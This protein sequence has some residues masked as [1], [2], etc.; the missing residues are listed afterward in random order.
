MEGKLVTLFMFMFMLSKYLFFSL[1]PKGPNSALMFLLLNN[2]NGGNLGRK[3]A[4]EA[5]GGPHSSPESTRELFISEALS[6]YFLLNLAIPSLTTTLHGAFTCSSLSSM[7]E[8]RWNRSNA[9]PLMTFYDE[10]VGKNP[11]LL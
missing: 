6:L 1:Y 4:A 9:A 8:M 7:K 2:P 11:Q 10:L 3:P 5:P